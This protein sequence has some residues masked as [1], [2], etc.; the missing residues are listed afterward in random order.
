MPSFRRRDSVIDADRVE[1]STADPGVSA[2]RAGTRAVQLLPEGEGGEVASQES[3]EDSDE[4]GRPHG[5]SA[6]NASGGAETGAPSTHTERR[7]PS[8]N[9]VR[10]AAYALGVLA[11]GALIAATVFMVA[12]HRQAV[13]DRQ[14][15][16]EFSAAARE[17]VVS[18]M[19]LDHT[20]AQDDVNRIIEKST[21]QFKADFQAAAGDF[22]KI[23]Q[24]SKV[25][26][27]VAVNATAVQKIDNGAADVLVAAASRVTNSSGAREQP[28][29][30]R[31]IVS[32]QREGDQIKMSK[33][34]FVP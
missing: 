17:A 28:R 11:T 33:V 22:V 30:W 27:D 16:A 15:Q 4:V 20:N 34:E 23:S 19:S 2:A 5:D 1:E 10:Y 14:E 9:I 18:L 31:L 32:L 29:S 21:G 12:Q 6:A 26:T 7:P 13:D 3:S 24:E 8:C 25:V